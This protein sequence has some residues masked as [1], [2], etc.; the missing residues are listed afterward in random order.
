MTVRSASLRQNPAYRPGNSRW[1]LIACVLLGGAVCGCHRQVPRQPVQG[2]VPS[3]PE[4][5]HA[6]AAWHLP[7]DLV[8]RAYAIAHRGHVVTTVDSSTTDD[9]MALE[10]EATMRR[11]PDGGAA[12]LVRMVRSQQAG[13]AMRELPGQAFPFAFAASPFM[14]GVSPSAETASA[15]LDPCTSPAAPA[16]LAIQDLLFAIPDTLHPG[17]TWGDSATS[18][19]CLGGVGITRSITRHFSFRGAI[20]QLDT[21]QVVRI[22]RT[23]RIALTG[24]AVRGIDST[25]VSGSGQAMMTLDLDVRTGAV[26]QGKGSSDLEVVVR[27]AVHV[28]RARQVMTT[29]VRRAAGRP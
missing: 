1:A 20:P 18:T 21:A 12:G 14:P 19:M 7:I 16:L 15:P 17:D 22:D 9:T 27:S 13:Q 25:H 29:D 23:T 28:Q 11:T 5:V 24:M 6:P 3:A 2:E 8:A 4:V 26:L 10:I